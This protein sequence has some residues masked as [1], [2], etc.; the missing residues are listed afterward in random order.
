MMD[1][2]SK[3]FEEEGDLNAQGEQGETVVIVLF[4]WTL[5]L[6]HLQSN[7]FI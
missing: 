5:V 3:Y 1:D 2:L 4:D 7:I 6:S